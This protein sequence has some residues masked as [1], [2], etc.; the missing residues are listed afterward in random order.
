M[1]NLTILSFLFLSAMGVQ[2]KIW[3]VNN[4]ASKDPDFTTVT[5]AI[6]TAAAGDTLHIE[7]SST[8]YPGF[9]LNKRLVIIGNGYFLSNNSGLQANTLTSDFSGNT[10]LINNIS[11]NGSV[12]SGLVVGT[13]SLTNVSNIT[14]SHCLINSVQASSYAV[15]GVGI[16]I[17]KC[18]I[19]SMDSGNSFSGNG[20]VTFTIENNIF[21]SQ[22]GQSNTTT[23]TM[24]T[25]SRGLFRNN[26]VN[27]G[28]NLVTL[29]NFYVSN[30]L[31]TVNTAQ[32]L[33]GNNNIIRNNL[34]A[35]SGIV[36]SGGNVNNLNS[37][38]MVATLVGPLTGTGP[39]ATGDSRFQ[40]KSGSP[41]AAAGETIGTVTNPACGAIGATDPY[42]LSGIP[43]VPSIYLLT[44]PGSVSPTA[45][46][47]GITISTRSNN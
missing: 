40:L 47:M 17:K 20:D 37:V 24:R 44:V 22:V 8:V 9:T 15:A 12:I 3:R 11:A 32:P 4:D 5:N 31:F 13:I 6:S 1:K 45:T 26:T 33:G 16:T 27:S 25:T 21:S 18:F 36:N 35:G 19:G 7:P 46:S 41:A 34:N 23:I 30:N 29:N 38:D 39:A 10:I 28:L 43:P 14:I 2:A 42:R